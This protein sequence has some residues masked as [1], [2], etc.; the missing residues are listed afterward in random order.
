MPLQIKQHMMQHYITF[1]IAVTDY[2]MPAWPI[3]VKIQILFI[4]KFVS[5]SMLQE[6][7]LKAEIM[8]FQF[9]HQL[10]IHKIGVPL[11]FKHYTELTLFYL[12]FPPKTSQKFIY[13]YL[14]TMLII[15]RF[16]H[17]ICAA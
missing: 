1:Y 12:F 3:L 2:G 13:T 10:L 5:S 9:F 8:F 15:L 17:H 14:R 11:S 7:L 6:D 4:L 16:E